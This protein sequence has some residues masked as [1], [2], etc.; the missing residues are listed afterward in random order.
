MT[1]NYLETDNY[2]FFYGSDFSQWAIRDI[3]IDEETFNC[4]EQYMM[5]R[6]ARLFDD[7]INAIKI[8]DSKYPSE[9][10]RY[11]RK[12]KNFNKHKWEEV[13]REVVYNANYAKFTQHEDLK[14][15]LLSTG[16]KTIVEA[17]PYDRIWE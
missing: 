1:N 6:K 8:G 13:A 4:N 11:G 10:K 3:E 14:S 17:S 5:T 12:V 2:I 16:D 7:P 15:L 9:Q